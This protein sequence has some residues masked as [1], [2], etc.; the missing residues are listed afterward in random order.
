V[1]S[2]CEDGL[3]ENQQE[4]VGWMYMYVYDYIEMCH[5]LLRCAHRYDT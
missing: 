5:S 1:T 2:I 4:D 3:P